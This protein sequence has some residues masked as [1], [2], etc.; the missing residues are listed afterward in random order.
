MKKLYAKNELLFAIVFIVL[1]VV[2]SSVAAAGSEKIGIPDSLTFVFHAALSVILLVFLCKNKLT[3][4]YGLCKTQIRSVHFL[5]YVPFAVLV[6]VNFWFGVGLQRSPL[7]SALQAG[8]M[9]CV[10]FL[11]EIIFRGLLFKAMAKDNVK[12]AVIVSSVTFGIGHI[13]NLFN[14]AQLLPTLCQILYATAFG[15]LCV[16]VFHKGK[17]L[18]PCIISHSAVNTLSVF[19]N[20]KTTDKQII[21]SSLALFVIAGAYALYLRKSL[22]ETKDTI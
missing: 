7:Q 19:A 3:T 5:Y 22:S 4:T 12:A 6:S 14:G 16:I 2:G 17:T 15:F 20:E 9:L 11:E 1:Y 18:L 21:L 8:S 13:I 10:G